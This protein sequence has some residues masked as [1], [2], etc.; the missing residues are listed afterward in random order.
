MGMSRF[1]AVVRG[2]KA[3]VAGGLA[4]DLVWFARYR[5]D[6]GDQS[7]RDWEL[8][9]GTTS[10]EEAGPPAQLGRLVARRVFLIELPD[11]AAAATNNVV[12]WAT[13]MQ[14]GALYGLASR[15]APGPLR[16]G[17]VLGALAC[18]TSYVVLPLLKLYKPIWKYDA[19]TLAKDYSAHLVFGTVTAVAFRALARIRR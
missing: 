4:M 9:N 14:W 8:S 6:G 13:A 17:V 1:G 16:R 10:F 12:H 19:K 15:S 5:D 11:Q 18:T 7:F 3:G 2:V